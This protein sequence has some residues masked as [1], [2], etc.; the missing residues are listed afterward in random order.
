MSKPIF[1]ITIFILTTSCEHKKLK[2]LPPKVIDTNIVLRTES[3]QIIEKDY[4][5]D[6]KTKLEWEN[7]PPLLNGK[8]TEYIN[9]KFNDENLLL[10]ENKSI[11][12]NYE[13]LE[14]GAVYLKIRQFIGSS[15]PFTGSVIGNVKELKVNGEV[16][17]I[18]DSDNLYFRI[19]TDVEIGYNRIPVEVINK[20]LVK[21]NSFIELY[22]PS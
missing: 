8:S 19:K 9:G 6:L 13:K 4:K 17:K 21:F 22:Y 1:L 7:D 20:R 10:T 16:I 14:R 11:Y 3:G 2:V 5:P 12:Y 18:T 15:I